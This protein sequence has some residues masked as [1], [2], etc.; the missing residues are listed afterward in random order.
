MEQG[1]LDD[2]EL[3]WK[4]FKFSDGKTQPIRL[5]G[6]RKYFREQEEAFRAYENSPEHK[7]RQRKIWFGEDYKNNK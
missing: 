5:I 1:A 6:T 3:I 2:N 4:E 7:E